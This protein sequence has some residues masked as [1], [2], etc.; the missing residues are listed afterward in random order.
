MTAKFDVRS[1]EKHM[2]LTS[3]VLPYFE[4]T[5]SDESKDAEDTR[6]VVVHVLT[7]IELQVLSKII[8]SWVDDPKITLLVK[9]EHLIKLMDLLLGR[10]ALYSSSLHDQEFNRVFSVL[11]EKLAE[12][13]YILSV[14]RDGNTSILDKRDLSYFA[15]VEFGTTLSMVL[16]YVSGVL[17]LSTDSREMDTM[18]GK[19]AHRLLLDRLTRNKSRLYSSNSYKSYH[20][21]LQE[22]FTLS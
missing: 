4:H 9:N 13:M 6:R 16:E 7:S 2:W 1:L 19:H 21:Y 8:F 12:F 15:S 3:I 18:V 5:Y 14:C 20:R 17:S 10:S 11:S 22:R